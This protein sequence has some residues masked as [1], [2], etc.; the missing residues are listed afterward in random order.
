MAEVYILLGGNVGDKSKIFKETKKLIND[1]I[2]L[3]T[4]QSSVYATEPWGFVS[5]LF[6]NQAII[7]ETTLD[8]FE[9]LQQSQAIE[10]SMGRI[11]LSDNYEART[12]DIDLLFYDDLQVNTP[13][14][15]IP[16]PKMDERKF[17]LIPLNDI[18]PE[19]IHPGS[20]LTV[21]E[22]LQKCKDQLN[23]ERIDQM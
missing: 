4:K 1:R 15:A 16:H 10:K 2:G 21:H 17:V 11:K 9:I 12:M 20:G 22:M 6:W 8:P 19:K 7:A 23:V 5:D 14:L 3:I 18:A 13:N